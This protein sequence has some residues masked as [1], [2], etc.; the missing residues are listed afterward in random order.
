MDTRLQPK[1]K[2]WSPEASRR[3]VYLPLPPRGRVPVRVTSDPGAS[4]LILRMGTRRSVGS[5]GK[6]SEAPST[7]GVFAIRGSGRHARLFRNREGRLP[8]PFQLGLGHPTLLF[9]PG[10]SP[11]FPPDSYSVS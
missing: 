10:W 8:P 11:F 2:R 3:T 6:A 7:P 5:V 4:V 9:S 1:G